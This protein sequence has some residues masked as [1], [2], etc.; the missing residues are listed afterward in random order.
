M[1]QQQAEDG[2]EDDQIDGDAGIESG[3]ESV[4]EGRMSHR[5]ASVGSVGPSTREDGSEL[6]GRTAEEWKG[7]CSRCCRVLLVS[8]VSAGCDVCANCAARPF[9]VDV[10]PDFVG[11]TR[12]QITR[13]QRV[14]SSL[15]EFGVEQVEEAVAA[16][17]QR[18]GP[19]R[20]HR[21]VRRWN[22]QA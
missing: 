18:C 9:D 16:E 14:S 2:R 10:E 15:G 8:S 3:V 21:G 17:G 11:P 22:F 4:F 19:G 5:G 12:G 13:F 20:A 6:L 1:D 7:V